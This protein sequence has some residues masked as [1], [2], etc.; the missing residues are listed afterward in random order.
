MLAVEAPPGAHKR[1]GHRAIAAALVPVAEQFR[2]L[3]AAGMPGR[4]RGTMP[5]H[6][7]TR[8]ASMGRAVARL[9]GAPPPA[10]LG[11]DEEAPAS[12]G[13]AMDLDP[14]LP[15]ARISEAVILVD[16]GRSAEA[17]AACGRA[18][19]VGG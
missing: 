11:R 6:V 1:H 16:T 12:C 4:G 14:A 17:H 5:E 13:T 3:T 2:G 9:A 19:E 8:L 15:D 10:R 18:V 7:K